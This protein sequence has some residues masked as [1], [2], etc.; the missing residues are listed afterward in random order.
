MHKVKGDNAIGA[1]PRWWQP[2][3]LAAVAGPL[4]GFVHVSVVLA[5][6]HVLNEFT[7]TSR[8]ILWM[9]PLANAV[10]LLLAAI[11]FSVV[12]AIRSR[13]LLWR[14]CV[15]SLCGLA[16]MS[17]L[18]TIG[19]LH[20]WAVF[21]LS[22]GIG[23]QLS[24]LHWHSIVLMRGAAGAAVLIALALVW[25]QTTWSPG[26]RADAPR[27]V[28]NVLVLIL[29]TVRASSTSLHGYTRSTTPNLDEIAR[30]GAMFEWA[31][32]PSS[33][34]LPSH[35]AMFTGRHASTLS[36]SWR[37]PLDETHPTVAEAF[38]A[39][40]YATGAFVANPFYTHHESGLERGF[41]V[42]RDFRRTWLQALWSTT[43]GQTPFLNAVLWDRTP[44]ALFAALKKFDLRVPAEPQFD[45]RWSPEVIDEFLR[46][47]A[48]MGPRPFFA[49]LNLFDAHDPYE[50]PRPVRNRFSASPT[51]QDL[52]DAGIA[53][54]DGALGR[55]FDTLRER[56]IMDRTLIVV[57]SDHGE[58]FGEHDLRN[59]GNSLYLPAVHVPLVIRYPS[60]VEP[61]TRVTQAVSLTDL[62]VTLVDGAGLP[63]GGLPGR[64]LLSAC[65]GSSTPYDALVV[66]ET[67]QL[68]RSRNTKAPAMHGPLASLFR[69]SLQFIR[70]GDST[71]QLFDVLHDY[72]QERD[73]H[74]DPRGCLAGV[75]MDS[76][77][78]QVARLPATPAYSAGHCV[79][80]VAVTGDA[81][82][83]SPR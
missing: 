45:R 63:Q 71:Y 35:A 81:R 64:S 27:G 38:R 78:R 42:L 33:W 56:G 11:P 1:G 19:G 14:I 25:T 41:D 18:L 20:P 66:T 73:L 48:E 31:I 53:Y 21:L 83:A 34:T 82:G 7:W 43:L 15:V 36:A 65:C 22:F 57:T 50:P 74:A 26:S 10:I 54:M 72:A 40:G 9:S 44:A 55:L 29:D 3:L 24:R 80:R 28:P 12:L 6:R 4:A 47:Q 13:T 61:G 77:L 23:L 30:E 75:A 17:A 5:R 69:D 76:M 16:A 52:Y 59:H 67:E 62:A 51:K 68:D 58:Q 60:R 46:W 49:F 70:N 37:K 2:L 79:G 8:D 39:A 32:A